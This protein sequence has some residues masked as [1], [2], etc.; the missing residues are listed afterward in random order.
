VGSVLPLVERTVNC[1]LPSGLAL[2]QH[3]GKGKGKVHLRTGHDGP[4]GE[5]RY[6]CTLSLTLALYGVGC[7]R[8]AMAVLPPGKTRY[9][10]YNR[11]GGPQGRSRRVREISSPAT[12]IL[13]PDRPARSQSLY[14]LSYPAR[15]RAERPRN[16][17]FSLDSIAI[18][19]IP[20]YPDHLW[21]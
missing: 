18:P 1:K 21:I 7:Q 4:G 19:V 2:L 16:F 9:P 3:K 5:E 20:M 12:G 14:R 10:L 15:L 6:S 17:L 13:S 8:Y 11:L